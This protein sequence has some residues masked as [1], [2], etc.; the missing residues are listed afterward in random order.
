MYFDPNSFNVREVD[1]HEDFIDEDL[2]ALGEEYF[3]PN[4]AVDWIY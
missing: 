2:L 4:E 3:D 1:D